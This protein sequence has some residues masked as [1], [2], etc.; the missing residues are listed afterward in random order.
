MTR[1]ASREPSCG[2]EILTAKRLPSREPHAHP[3]KEVNG[4]STPSSEC[5]N[6][7]GTSTITSMPYPDCCDRNQTFHLWKTRLPHSLS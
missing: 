1:G 6:E 5:P 4:M 3:T 2:S 7:V